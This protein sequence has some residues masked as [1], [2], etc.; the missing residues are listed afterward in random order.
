MSGKWIELISQVGLG[1]K[2]VGIASVVFGLFAMVI[3]TQPLTVLT[4]TNIEKIYFSKE[5]NLFIKMGRHIFL[6]VVASLFSPILIWVYYLLNVNEYFLNIC[7]IIY[8]LSLI[9]S[10]Y[11]TYTKRKN[12]GKSTLYKT[13][14]FT[15]LFI[16]FL[17]LFSIIPISISVALNKG[18]L[19]YKNNINFNIYLGISLLIIIFIFSLLLVAFAKGMFEHFRFSWSEYSKEVFYVVE[20]DTNKKWFLYH[21]IDKN[22]ILVGDALDFKK[23]AVFKTIS[24]EDLF[25]QEIHKDKI[26]KEDHSYARPIEYLI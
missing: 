24:K 21:L 26:F 2:Y 6:S 1:A 10:S 12:R 9:I 14:T 5:K 4:S 20:K 11:F 8:L 15:L 25:K 16:A 7:A 3:K 17:Q 19:F 23:A 18:E 13:L 22:N